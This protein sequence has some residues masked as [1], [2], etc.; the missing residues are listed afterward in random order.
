MT[1]KIDPDK[2]AGTDTTDKR[3]HT[4]RELGAINA[5]EKFIKDATARN[6]NGIDGQSHGLNRTAI[7]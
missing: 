4:K 1:R 7:M 6:N 2:I 5:R 3:S